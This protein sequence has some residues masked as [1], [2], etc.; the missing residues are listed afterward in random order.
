MAGLESL[1]QLGICRP[2]SIV[3]YASAEPFPG[4]YQGNFESR[5]GQNIRS[6]SASRTAP[7]DTNIENLLEHLFSPSQRKFSTAPPGA[8]SGCNHIDV[9][10][11]VDIDG[12]NLNSALGL[13]SV[14]DDVLNELPLLLRLAIPV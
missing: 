8:F 2:V 4:L 13:G 12:D 11:A 1:F 14:V 3:V 10:V 7:Y 5:V 6:D 9:T